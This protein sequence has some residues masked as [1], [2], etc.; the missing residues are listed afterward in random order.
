MS[1]IRN[2]N[3]RTVLLQ[4]APPTFQYPHFI[5]ESEYH[6]NSNV[7]S[8]RRRRRSRQRNRNTKSSTVFTID[9]EPSLTA[10]TAPRDIRLA[11]TKI[12]AELT[13]YFDAICLCHHDDEN[14]SDNFFNLYR[15]EEE[16]ENNMREILS[17]H[18]KVLLIGSVEVHERRKEILVGLKRTPLCVEKSSPRIVEK[19]P[20]VYLYHGDDGEGDGD[21]D[22]EK[23]ETAKTL[24]ERERMMAKRLHG[25]GGYVSHKKPVS[26]VRKNF[27]QYVRKFCLDELSRYKL[28]KH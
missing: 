13:P 9:V 8:R 19:F 23:E 4:T 25:G 28:K 16:R 6:Y 27:V 17:T 22:E 15:Y 21:Q 26:I 10:S 11:K 24:K 20:G 18:P 3:V 2:N 5:C 12:V 7:Q 1:T 14:F